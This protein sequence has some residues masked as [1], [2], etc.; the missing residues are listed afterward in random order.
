MKFFILKL[1]S[2]LLVRLKLKSLSIDVIS[3]TLFRQSKSFDLFFLVFL[4]CFA[5][6]WTFY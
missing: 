6:I 2:Q 4:E 3:F 5:L 1:N